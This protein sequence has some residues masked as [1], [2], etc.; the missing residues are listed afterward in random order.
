MP[1]KGGVLIVIGIQQSVQPDINGNYMRSVLHGYV[2]CTGA[3]PK[4]TSSAL[5]LHSYRTD[6]RLPRKASWRI[7]GMALLVRCSPKNDDLA[8]TRASEYRQKS[9]RR[10]QEF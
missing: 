2:G 1:E 6:A 9:R 8:I 5:L 10:K 4:A 3:T 7:S